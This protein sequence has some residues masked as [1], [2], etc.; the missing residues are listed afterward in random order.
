MPEDMTGTPVPESEVAADLGFADTHEF[1][2]W[3]TDLGRKV[4]EREHELRQARDE[5]RG[6]RWHG[7]RMQAVLER[8]ETAM[9]AM[10]PE[11]FRLAIGVALNKAV[12]WEH[13]LEGWFPEEETDMTGDGDCEQE[14]MAWLE[15]IR[16]PQAEIERLAAERDA[17][18]EQC[19]TLSRDILRIAEQRAAA[20][21]RAEAAEEECNGLKLAIDAG[22]AKAM[23]R[24]SLAEYRE[25]GTGATR[26]T[27]DPD[28]GAKAAYAQVPDRADPGDFAAWDD[29]PEAERVYWRRVARVVAAAIAPPPSPDVAGL[30]ERA[31]DALTFDEP[32]SNRTDDQRSI[33][34]RYHELK[35]EMP[36]WRDAA[37]QARVEWLS[38]LLAAAGLGARHSIAERIEWARGQFAAAEDGDTGGAQAWHGYIQ[39]LR[40]CR[41]F[42]A[43]SPEGDTGAREAAR[44]HSELLRRIEAKIVP[45]VPAA[46]VQCVTGEFHT[47]DQDGDARDFVDARFKAGLPV[48]GIMTIQHWTHHPAAGPGVA[49]GGG[50]DG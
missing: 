48:Y 17:A 25:D 30:A 37:R 1:R 28:A 2:R 27:D 40:W 20:T 3:Q 36:A 32:R 33:R 41:E 34:D 38:R 42:A 9:G 19:N 31:V 8:I 23:I 39:A 11:D 43:I 26:P 35:D 10:M 46:I 15:D 29:L 24:A 7:R 50:G 47:F 4:A 6:Y 5:A 49:R 21:A 13:R 14:D 45:V 22:N 18:V 12:D 16:K 44:E